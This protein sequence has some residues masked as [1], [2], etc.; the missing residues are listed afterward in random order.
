MKNILLKLKNF[1][2]WVY[3][4][5]PAF[6]LENGWFNESLAGFVGG[7]FFMLIFGGSL[8]WT[9]I[10]FNIISV[11]YETVIDPNGWDI[12]DVLMRVPALVLAMTLW[13]L[14]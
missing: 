3:S 10:V 5:E 13:K 8:L 14:L 1:M 4:K 2:L 6:L 9:F 11:L 7:L 12:E